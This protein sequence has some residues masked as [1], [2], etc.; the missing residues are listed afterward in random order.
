MREHGRQARRQE[1]ERMSDDHAFPR[2]AR[3]SD[4]CA[5]WA[6][7]TPHAEAAV[8]GDL[9]LSHAKLSEEIDLLAKAL[10]AAG[11]RK[12]DRVATLSTPHPDYLIAFLATASIGAIWLGLNPKYRME[13]LNYAVADAE[14]CILLARREIEGRDYAAELDGLLW[15]NACVRRLVTLPGVGLEGATAYGDFLRAGEQISDDQLAAARASCGGRDP[16]LIVY[17]SGSTGKPKGALLHHEGLVAAA[18]EQNRNW[19]MHPLRVVNYFPI[20]HVGCVADISTPAIV[21]GGALIFMEHFDPRRCL[22]L[23]QKEDVTFWATVP[24]V[25]HLQLALPDF[26]SFDLS[27]LQLIVWEG[28]AIPAETLDRLLTIGP[29]LGTNFSMTESICAITVTTPTKDREVLAGSVG[30]PADG[31]EIRLVDSQGEIVDGV[32]MIGE[33][34]T[35]SIYNMLG[36]WRRPEANAETIDAEGWMRTGDTAIR[37]TDGRYRIVGRIKEMFKSG[38]YNV[39]PREVETAIEA[40]PLI[41]QAAVVSVPDDVWQEV[42]VAFVTLRGPLTNEALNTH[43]RERLANYKIPKSFIVLDEMPL[44]PIGK[45]DKAALTRQARAATAA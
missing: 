16:C 15:Q 19:P 5:H 36:Y 2:F 33:L 13:E 1:E 42:G 6:T 20:N 8:L 24:S 21:A 4:Y 37:R 34:Q 28:A 3:I 38:G 39:Y 32:D 7:K 35:R 22:E 14:P 27:A 29:P 9:R 10:L 43:C 44:L 41:D 12:G 31:V 30:L 23:M 11:V 18:L 17:T 45:I 40:H 26:A 25:F